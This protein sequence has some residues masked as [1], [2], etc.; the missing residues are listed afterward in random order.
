MSEPCHNCHRAEC[1]LLAIPDAD[2]HQGLCLP[3]RDEDGLPDFFGGAPCLTCD[4]A[5]VARADCGAHWVDWRAR[6]LAAEA[7]L[8]E[9]QAEAI[10]WQ[11][12]SQPFDAAHR[13]ATSIY[14][15]LPKEPKP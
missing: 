13:C 6:A 11:G 10:H 15:L 5:T 7:T 4:E 2:H 1:P 3:V 12:F 14:S 8:A 9:V